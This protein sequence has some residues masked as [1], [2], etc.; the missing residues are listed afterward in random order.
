MSPA[1]STTSSTSSTGRP[2]QAGLELITD[3]DADLHI[4]GHARSLEQAVANLLA[5]AVRFA[6]DQSAIAIA[7]GAE[8]GW[9]WITVADQ[10][11]VHL[12]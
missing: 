11:P 6:P 10:G 5:N 12:S 9:V 4:V 8:A 2:E 7:A 1:S 3:V